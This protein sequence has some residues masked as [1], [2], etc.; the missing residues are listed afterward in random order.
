MV[1]DTLHVAGR[2]ISAEHV[3]VVLVGTV[4]ELGWDALRAPTTTTAN[5]HIA[6]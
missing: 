6:T 5:K 4:G 3:V 1:N 2:S